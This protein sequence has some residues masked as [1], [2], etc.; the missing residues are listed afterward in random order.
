MAIDNLK[1]LYCS[2]NEITD[3]YDITYLEKLEVLDLE[4]NK[5]EDFQ[6]ITYLQGNSELRDLTI[7]W[8]PMAMEKNFRKRV[9]RVLPQLKYLDS[10]DVKALRSVPKDK[11]EIGNRYELEENAL[12]NSTMMK[13]VHL[14]PNLT[15]MEQEAKGALQKFQEEDSDEHL[16]INAI[17]SAEYKKF[18]FEKKGDYDYSEFDDTW[19]MTSTSNFFTAEDRSEAEDDGMEF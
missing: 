15:E 7:E 12:I 4:A 17:K 9:S 10:L 13:F 2:Y 16:I 1:E 8:N 6:N 18:A 3:I 11:T 14:W 5:I 19:S